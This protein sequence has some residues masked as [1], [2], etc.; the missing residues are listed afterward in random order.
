MQISAEVLGILVVF[1]IFCLLIF[2]GYIISS[3]IRR[4]AKVMTT[5]LYGA[6]D[7]FLTR[8]RKKAI[9]MIVEKNADKKMEEQESGEPGD[10]TPDIY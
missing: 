2:L 3:R 10:K 9:E 6:T 5:V 4:G 1:G 8:D 7:E